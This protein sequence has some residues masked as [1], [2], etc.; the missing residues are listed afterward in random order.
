MTRGLLLGGQDVAGLS[1][2]ELSAL[3]GRVP[4]S[5]FQQTVVGGGW[6]GASPRR[7]GLTRL[8]GRGPGR[9]GRVR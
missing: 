8:V 6:K 2:R 7:T 4:G 5:V 9:R 1:D 3:L